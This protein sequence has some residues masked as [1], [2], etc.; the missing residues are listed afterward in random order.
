MTDPICPCRS[1]LVPRNAE[2]L[3]KEYNIDTGQQI[4]ALN[5]SFS[6]TSGIS[7]P[8]QIYVH[9]STITCRGCDE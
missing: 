5:P 9:R 1:W 7:N 3:S 8:F 4:C 2:N 6:P